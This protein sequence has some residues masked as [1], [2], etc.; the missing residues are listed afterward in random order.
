M[1]KIV[2][3]VVSVAM[4]ALLFAATASAAGPASSAY[5]GPNVNIRTITSTSTLPFTGISVP[6]ILAIAAVLVACGLLLRRTLL[7]AA[8]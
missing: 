1:R 2:S 3:S 7:T 8:D 5:G 6:A 4:L